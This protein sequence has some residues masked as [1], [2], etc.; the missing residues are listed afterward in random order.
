MAALARPPSLPEPP[1]LLYFVGFML[2]AKAMTKLLNH[3]CG[4]ACPSAKLNVLEA[5]WNAA[6]ESNQAALKKGLGGSVGSPGYMS[7][8]C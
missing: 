8:A 3:L 2:L 5:P 6:G 4:S 1:I 7:Q